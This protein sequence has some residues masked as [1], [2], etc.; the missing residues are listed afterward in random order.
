[1]AR[2]S[3]PL[4]KRAS[5]VSDSIPAPIGG[6]NA[7]DALG[8]MA[9]T[10]A[11]TLVNFWPLPSDVMVRKGY[12]RY[13]TGL[14]GQ[15]ESLMTY[16]G[17]SSNKF[18][19]AS[20]TSFYDVTSSGAV[21]AAVVTGLTNARWQYV[22]MTTAGGSFLMA[23]NGADKLRGYNGTAWYTDGDGSHDI[24][25]VNTANCIHINLFK[26]RVWLIEKNTLN[27]WYLGTDAISGAATKFS[28]QS[29]AKRGGYLVAMGTWT[30]DAGY[31]VDDLA[32][33][34]TSEGEVIVYRGT[35]PTSSSTWALVGIWALGAPIGTRC[36]MKYAG[37]M[38]LIS[39]D[40]VVPLSGAL[41]SSRLNPKVALTD[42]IQSAMSEAATSYGSNFG[43]QLLYYAKANMLLLNVPVQEGG[44]QEQY[45]MNTIT[46]SWAD[47]SGWNANC[48]EIYQEEPYFG[49]NGFVGKAWDT[50]ADNMTNV[51]ANATQAF[52]YFE[53]RSQ[54]KR[55][56]MMRT[57][58]LTNGS[59]ALNASLAIDFQDISNT[60]ALAFSPPTASLWDSA[61]WDTA[62]WGGGLSLVKQWK[63]ASGVGRCAA[64]MLNVASNGIEVHWVST[65]LVMERGGIL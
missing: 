40:G 47:F 13:A 31:G 14:P 58:L 56:T 35:D 23:V 27:A 5:A 28:F 8:E 6:W 10:D 57:I 29:I 54:T 53:S 21:G 52:N 11:V 55:F 61:V 39:Q 18:F 25:G 59:P 3:A 63:G 30:I 44:F 1:M 16:A 45:V 17:G 2:N 9:P 32:V 19:A 60:S 33:W 37:D 50:F 4:I 42:K 12:S 51:N 48:W 22:N 62:T 20:V 15:A 26:S 46:K 65:D 41:Q 36:L 64:P 43:W 24:T 38:L 49:G 7:R 34:V